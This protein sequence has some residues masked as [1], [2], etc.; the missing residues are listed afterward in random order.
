M[1]NQSDVI[2]YWSLL[3][4]GLIEAVATPLSWVFSLPLVVVPLVILLR[5]ASVRGR[6]PA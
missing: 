6:I 4:I 5:F 2:V 1:P 3:G